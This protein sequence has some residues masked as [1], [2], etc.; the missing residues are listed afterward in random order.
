MNLIGAIALITRDPSD[1]SFDDTY[2]SSFVMLAS[3][4]RCRVEVWNLVDKYCL[5]LKIKH[6]KIID[7]C[8]TALST[9]DGYTVDDEDF[10]HFSPQNVVVA[11][12]KV[13]AA[14]GIPSDNK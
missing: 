2:E 9:L 8:K 5:K 3:N 7:E 14:I 11:I 4:P 12:E 1:D 13:A 10:I 6:E